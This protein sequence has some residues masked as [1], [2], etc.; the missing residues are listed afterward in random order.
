MPGRAVG[1]GFAL[2]EGVKEFGPPTAFSVGDGALDVAGAL[3]CDDGAFVSVGFSLVSELQALSA[4]IPTIASAPA[5][6]ANC[7][8]NVDAIV[9]P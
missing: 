6:S 7:R 1:A 5:A 3:D 9:S 8:V 4:P 2:T